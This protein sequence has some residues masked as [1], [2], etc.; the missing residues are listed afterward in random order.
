VRAPAAA[1]RASP[2]DRPLDRAD[3][4]IARHHSTGVGE[5]GLGILQAV[6]G[7]HADHPL[8][9]VDAVADQAGDAASICSSVPACTAPPEEFM[10]S[11]ASSQRA[12][13]PIRIALA[14]VSG[15]AI[16]APWTSGAA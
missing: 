11:I 15:W 8:R 10:A 9:P 5:R 14:I 3:V 2:Q 13:L 4:R 7:E 12:G 6:A 16:G 1:A